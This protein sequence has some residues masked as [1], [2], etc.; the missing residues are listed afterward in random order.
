MNLIKTFTNSDNKI[1]H[2]EVALSHTEDEVTTTVSDIFELRE[3]VEEPITEERAIK[4]IAVWASQIQ[5]LQ[6]ALLTKISIASHTE[7]AV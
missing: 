6:K 4:S 3:A 7:T 5:A 1:T 2:V